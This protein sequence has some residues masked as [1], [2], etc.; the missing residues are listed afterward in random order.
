MKYLFISEVAGTGSTGR[1]AAEQC[2]TLMAQGHQCLLAY[3]RFHNGC[4]DVPTYRIGSKA[5][6]C[7]HALQARLLD[8]AGFGSRAATRRFL[9]RVREYDPDV[10]W[11]H[12]VHGYY[13]HIGLLFDYLHTCGKEIHWMLHDCWAFTG[14]CAYFDYCG[15]DRWKTGCHDCPE[16]KKYPASLL[17]DNSR[18]NYREKK[19][20]FT[21][22]PNLSLTVPSQWL[23][24]RVAGSFLKE[25]PVEVVPNRVNREV[26]RPTPGD[27]RERY[28]LTD[29]KIVLGV[30]NVWDARKGLS[31][32]VALSRMLDSCFRIVLIG[33]SPKQ[34]KSLPG[35]ILGLPRTHSAR[36]LAE[37]YTAADV[38]VNPS[39]EETFG[40]TSLEAACCGTPAIVYKGTACEEAARQF[41]G[42]AVERGTENLYRAILTVI[43]ENAK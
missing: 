32:F 2:R 28:G 27:F 23:A 18:R 6:V 29:R 13:V 37:A 9:K 15:C 26:F 36:E 34:I 22:I 16:K 1:I 20:L 19:R 25:Y 7:L 35:E 5:G 40:I 4:P 33:L 41:D 11:L 8:D 21:G 39:V 43:G 10:I 38:F 42:I 12:N 31:D 24:D 30:A 17:L 3:G 14:H